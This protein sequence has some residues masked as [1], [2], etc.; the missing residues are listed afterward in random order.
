VFYYGKGNM[1]AL[2]RFDRAILQPSHYT[3]LELGWLKRH[4]VTTLA[5]L[6][7]SK[8]N[9]KARQQQRVLKRSSNIGTQSISEQVK[10]AFSLGFE[11]L[12]L[13]MVEAQNPLEK[14]QKLELLRE[15]RKLADHR[16]ILVNRGFSLMPELLG[17]VNGIVFEAFST[18]WNHKHGYALLPKRDLA[19]SAAIA[20]QLRHHQTPVYALDYADT[21]ELKH[22]A[23]RRAEHFGFTSLIANRELTQL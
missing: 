12:F 8:D 4:G 17:I 15:F 3:P 7:L 18:Q 9:P 16:T 13:D 14:K 10:I 19:W 21:I 1:S 11:G 22:F 6:D 20:T 5:F 23:R 2:T